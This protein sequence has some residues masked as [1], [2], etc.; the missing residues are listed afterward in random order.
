MGPSEMTFYYNVDVGNI[1]K[2]IKEG[3]KQSKVDWKENLGKLLG[4][5]KP[6]RNS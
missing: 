6:R 3:E 5:V 1:L 2:Y 4:K